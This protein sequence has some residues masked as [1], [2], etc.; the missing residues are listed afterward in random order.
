MTEIV[1]TNTERCETYR[2]NDCKEKGSI[3]LLH[4]YTLYKP[5]PMFQFIVHN[6]HLDKFDSWIFFFAF[7]S[8]SFIFPRQFLWFFMLKWISRRMKFT[9]H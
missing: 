9:A 6:I 5:T 1:Y 4:K 7:I 2:A 3:L 8:N